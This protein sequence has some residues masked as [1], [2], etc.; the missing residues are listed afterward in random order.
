MTHKDSVSIL[1]CIVFLLTA[2]GSAF[3]QTAGSAFPQSATVGPPQ[4]AWTDSTLPDAAARARVG[5]FLST[6]QEPPG[7]ALP[8][9]DSIAREAPLT[10]ET[11]AEFPSLAAPLA[12]PVLFR[13]TNLD[14]GATAGITSGIGEPSTANSGNFV[15][16]SGNWYASLSRDGGSTFTFVNPFTTFPASDGGFCCDQVVAYDAKRDLVFWL[17]QYIEDGTRNRQR[18]AVT[19]AADFDTVGWWY[20]DFVSDLTFGW[21]GQ[22]FDFPD[23]SV[24]DNYVYLTS[25]VFTI[26]TNSFVRTVIMRLPLDPISTGSAFGFNFVGDNTHGSFRTAQGIRST[27]Y[28]AAH[29][30]TTSIRVHRWDEGSPSYSFSDITLGAWNNA[31]RV[32]PGPDAR[33]W[34][35]RADS[36]ILGAGLANGALTFMWSASQGGS[37]AY[38]YVDVARIDAST[39]ALLS[40]PIIWNGSYAYI[41]PAIGVNSRGAL[42][43]SLF[44]GGG[45]L[46]PSHAIGIIDETTAGAADVQITETSTQGP[47]TNRWGDFVAARPHSPDNVTW[48]ATGYTMQGGGGDSNARP[49][50][51]WFGRCYYTLAPSV[52]SIV[53]AGGVG[54]VSITTPPGCAWAAA[55]NAAWLTITSGASGTGNGTTNFSVAA[56]PSGD[57]RIGSLT[58]GG[59]TVDFIQR[60]TSGGQTF[61]DVPVTH[62]FFDN[63]TL[64]YRRGITGGCSASP[65]LYCPDSPTTRGQM[66]VF[67]I[68]G[69]LGTDVFPY[70]ATPWFTDVPVSH[71]YF[72]WIQ[73]MRDLGI[74]SGCTATTYC[75]DASVS[76]DQMAVFIVRGKLTDSFSSAA[77][78]FFNDVLS[79]NV[80][81]RYIQKMKE[82]G[83]TSGCTATDYCPASTVTRGQMAVFITR[84][85]FSVP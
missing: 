34:C 1:V 77:L 75:P 36:R 18:L 25:N 50:N 26:G 27:A 48:L 53:A 2:F 73:K 58:I 35:G 74:T 11:G 69:K 10:P 64:L 84:A 49:L 63:I 37:F 54:S 41:Y 38:P 68:R 29:N 67:I 40:Q 44:V 7:P 14:A 3:A 46:L 72:K 43:L 60:G 4:R 66:A 65:P 17:L 21:T 16:Q 9:S 57:P 70:T 55:S 79:P 76:R 51:G 30:S 45:S 62:P 52:S 12:S 22:W 13:K 61:N 33:D 5:A 24:G 78:P 81:Y 83:I 71:P 6:H 15:F 31:T 28:W 20:Y 42:G 23:L 47:T 59:L 56:T 32:C 80:Y 82:L 8:G 39:M 19:R 85:F